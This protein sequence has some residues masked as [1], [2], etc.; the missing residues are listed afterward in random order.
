MRSLFLFG[1]EMGGYCG[2]LFGGFVGQRRKKGGRGRKEVRIRIRVFG[3]VN[4]EDGYSS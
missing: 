2:D 4:R 3:N 1:R